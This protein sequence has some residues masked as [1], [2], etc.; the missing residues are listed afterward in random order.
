M[1]ANNKTPNQKTTGYIL[2]PKVNTAMKTT[3]KA[4]SYPI[5]LLD[6]KQVNGYDASLTSN[7]PTFGSGATATYGVAFADWSD[8][9]VAQWGSIDLIVDSVTQAT[10]GRVRIVVNCYFDAAFRR[11]V[12]YVLGKMK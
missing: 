6:N 2:H 5:F 8:L 12:S 4:G 10:K 11:S 9:I 1:L 3:A 7:M